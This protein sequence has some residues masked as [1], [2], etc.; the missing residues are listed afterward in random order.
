[1]KRYE[2]VLDDHACLGQFD[3]LREALRT[4]RQYSGVGVCRIHDHF[5]EH[6]QLALII[7]M[8]ASRGRDPAEI[9]SVLL[10]AGFRRKLKRNHC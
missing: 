2:V 4:A 9:I 7:E 8:M 10:Q 5:E 6:P 3:H 1:M